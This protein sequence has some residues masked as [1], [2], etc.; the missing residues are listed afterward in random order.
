MLIGLKETKPSEAQYICRGVLVTMCHP[1]PIATGAKG[2]VR[3]LYGSEGLLRAPEPEAESGKRLDPGRVAELI[4]RA[5]YH[6]LDSCWIAKHPVL[7]LGEPTIPYYKCSIS[8]KPMP[9]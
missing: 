4:I 3:S 2:Q 5:T 9:L 1:G 8:L 7:L 6:G